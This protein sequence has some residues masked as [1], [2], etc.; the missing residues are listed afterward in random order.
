MQNN[1]YTLVSNYDPT[2]T[3][4]LR[5]AFVKD[6]NTRFDELIK[7]INISV[8][9]ND[10]FGLNSLQ[11]MQM[12]P[13]GQNMFAFGTSETKLA[14]FLIW[15]QEQIDKGLITVQDLE[16][17]GTGV[18]GAWTNKY[19]S[20][21]YKRGV[22]RA[23]YELIKAGYDVPTIEESGG[24]NVVMANPFHIDRLGLIFIR[25]YTD[26]KG[27]T[28]AMDM[29]ISRIL[30]QG[31]ADGDGPRLLAR[32][33]VAVI[34]GTGV[35]QLGIT[36]T[37]GRFIPAK[38]RAEILAR[39]EI[40]RAHHLANV[41]EY[42]N[43]RVLGVNVIAEVVNAGDKRVC[44]KCLELTK[45]NPYTLEQVQYLIPQHAQ[46]RCCIIPQIVH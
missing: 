35:D 10:V 30:A 5:N 24:I 8:E 38:R 20:D 14:Q 42:K 22:I 12:T 26:L 39:T 45:G 21:S 4:V 29:Q 46:C 44:S 13:A 11:N 23:R 3:T 41:Q 31:L 36:D 37:L 1:T 17:I 2:H 7:V 27:I 6:M 40:I 15:L 33:I 18:Q 32:K 9:T 25:T 43:W 16:Q 28:A 34:N 19:V